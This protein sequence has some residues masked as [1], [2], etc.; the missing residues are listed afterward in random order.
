MVSC[1]PLFLALTAQLEA[2]QLAAGDASSALNARSD[3]LDARLQDVPVHAREEALHGVRRGAAVALAIA[4]V[5][6]SHDLR[7][8]EPKFL[9]ECDRTA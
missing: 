3:T 4:H 8:V 7:L 2:L 9:E 6:S 5:R 1:I